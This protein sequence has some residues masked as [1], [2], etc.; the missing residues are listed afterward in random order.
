MGRVRELVRE[1][2][3]ETWLLYLRR[4][5]A[6]GN[7]EVLAKHTTKNEAGKEE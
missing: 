7:S 1:G 2:K 4:D 5:G 6:E 3:G